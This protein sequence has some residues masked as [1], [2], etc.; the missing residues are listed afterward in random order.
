MY[1]GAWGQHFVE[2]VKKAGGK[3]TMEDMKRYAPTW[4]EPLSTTFM[5]RTIYVPGKSNESSYPVL[6]S[7][8]LAE[9]LKLDAMGP[10]NKDAKGFRALTGLLRKA[11]AD[12]YTDQYMRQQGCLLYTSRCV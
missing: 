8:N 9:E 4:E 5:G 10:Y 6:E 12:S 2:A 1:S 3:A 11:E 7:L